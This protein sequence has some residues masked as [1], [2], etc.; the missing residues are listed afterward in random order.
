MVLTEE[1]RKD[2]Q[3]K[4]QKAN[5]EKI[6]QQRKEYREANKE[7]IKESKKKHRETNKEQIKQRKKKYYQTEE[8]KKK[9]KIS[10]WKRAGVICDDFN[11]LYDIYKNTNIC[12]ICNIKLIEGRCGAN[13]RCL[14][15]NHKTGEFRQI[16]CS[17]CNTST[18]RNIDQPKLTKAE[19]AWKYRLKKFIL[20]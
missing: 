1:Q 11:S 13:H 12:N 16:L 15:H 18:Q 7:K 4:Y 14:D 19:I 9:H 6:K 3:K 5:K 20:S 8:G 10:S 17:T 2:Y